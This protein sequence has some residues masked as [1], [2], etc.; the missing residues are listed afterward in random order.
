MD[1][2]VTDAFMGLWLPGEIICP[3]CAYGGYPTLVSYLGLKDTQSL[4]PDGSK[5]LQYDCPS[6]EQFAWP[7][8]CCNLEK[9]NHHRS[10][11][12]AKR[13]RDYDD[14]DSPDSSFGQMESEHNSGAEYDAPN[15][16]RIDW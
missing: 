14:D 7:A 3:L 12:S 2:Q 9:R 5:T 6:C 15:G 4:G 11:M 16:A 10:T 13:S 8:S 1:I